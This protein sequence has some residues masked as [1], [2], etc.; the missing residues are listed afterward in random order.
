MIVRS[1][2]A[3]AALA[4]PS[5][6]QAERWRTEFID[7]EIPM[8]DARHLLADAYLPAKPGRYPTILVQTP[9]NKA[10][11]RAALSK[12]VMLDKVGAIGR[13]AISDVVA[14]KDREH[15]A[16]VIVD[17]RGFYASKAAMRGVK[18]LRWRRA[19]DGF[20]TVEWIAKQPWSNGKV[21]TW[22]GS[23]LGKQQFD[24][25]AEHPPH[26]VCAAPMIAAMGLSYEQYF[27]RGVP[28]DA[29]LRMLDL[30]GYDLRARVRKNPLPGTLFWRFVRR[31]TYRPDKID[32]PCLM[33]TG[34]W[35]N[36]PDE[37]I[38]TF[39]DLV[40]RGGTAAREQSK[41]LIG[42]WDHVGVGL[43][44][45]G[46]LE[47]PKAALESAKA[48]KA[49][50][51]FHLRGL[52][53]GWDKTP[54]VRYF[55]SGSR[56]WHSAASWTGVPREQVVLYATGEGRLQRAK[57]EQ[58]KTRGYSYDP[59][60]PSR[61]LGGANLPPLAHGPLVQNRL[62]E[63]KDVLVYRT[64]SL[65]EALPLCGKL[66]LEFTFTAD[67]VDA[68]FCLR[69]CDVD[70]EGRAWLLTDTAVRAKLRNGKVELL[71]P[72]KPT[73]ISVAFPAECHT[74]AKG[75][76]LLVIL[77]SGNAPRYERNPHTGADLWDRRAAQ[78]VA[79]EISHTSDAPFVVRVPHAK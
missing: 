53:N 23:A 74:F 34:W 49:F 39:E 30:L 57:H 11:F 13:G 37:V 22:G 40:A 58:G 20:D 64:G 78:P 41:L 14:M 21:G 3:L 36:Y 9:Y 42:P 7:L 70:T 6:A 28:L 32:V 35:D 76:E 1:L 12:A 26:L 61:T 15:Y 52:A 56:T 71:E 24:T 45:Q 10:H 18:K 43:E 38:E 46:G 55:D 62:L 65:D 54:R 31:V 16:Y 44:K 27:D 4:V 79:I 63:R 17:W 33:I 50:F 59:K 75:H 72:G 29:H 48:A 73:R 51:D 77:T 5:A 69:L 19:Q 8:R 60:K 68:D 66:E 67:R 47:F 25:A 2:V